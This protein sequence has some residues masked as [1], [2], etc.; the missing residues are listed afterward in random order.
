MNRWRREPLRSLGTWHG[1]GTP[2]K[3]RPDFWQGGSIP[4]LSPKDMGP[5]VLSGT[6]D[7]ITPAAV[8]GSA[9]RL[10]KPGSVAVVVRSCILERTIPVA[11]V[12]FTTT[13][14]QD[15]KAIECRWDVEPRWVA[16]GLRASERQLLRTARKAGT[17]VASLEWGRFLDWEL[18]VPPLDE[19]R[20]ILDILEDHLSR[21]DA[22]QDYLGAAFKR[23]ESLKAAALRS[24]AAVTDPSASLRSLAVTCDYGTSTKC[25]ADGPGAA[26]VRIP[27]L[28]GGGIDLTDE[29]RALDDRVDLS[30]VMLRPGDLLIV[31]T[32]G[33]KNLIGR[34]AVVQPGI[35]AAFASYL[36][37]A[38]Q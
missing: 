15:M 11:L 16:W 22:A 20:R 6:R 35:D 38:L 23:T 31:R 29:K 25:V 33:S 9:T 28:R 32:N 17:T 27:N 12:P 10:V 3:G 19:Q 34:T 36:A 26:V 13:L 24:L 21:L 4:W 1:G 7:H 37:P 18:P 14:N 8:A 5:D 30:N 2:A